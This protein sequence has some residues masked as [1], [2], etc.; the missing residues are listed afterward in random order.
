MNSTEQL[1]ARMALI[2]TQ[3]AAVL[4][5]NAIGYADRLQRFPHVAPAVFADTV[6]CLQER[7]PALLADWQTLYRQWLAA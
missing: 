7:V 3:M 2:T 4:P 1:Q 6:R 5:R